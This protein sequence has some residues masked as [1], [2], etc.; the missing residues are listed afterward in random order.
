MYP[1]SKIQLKLFLQKADRVARSNYLQKII[2]QDGT[3]LS[4]SWSKGVGGGFSNNFPEE[5]AVDALMLTV[6]MFVQNNDQVSFASLAKLI[7]DV[8]ISD[9][10]KER[11]NDV[12]KKLN[13]FLDGNSI[14]NLD[15]KIYTHMEVFEVFLYGHLA[16]LNRTKVNLYNKWSKNPL[17]FPMIENEFH[18][19]VTTLLNAVSYLAYFTRLELAGEEITLPG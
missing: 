17:G 19:T 14:L 6:R 13:E 3:R 7:D 18:L 1:S 9:G 4:F 10:W 11:F 2:K 16:H 8:G 15:G 12:R 5:E